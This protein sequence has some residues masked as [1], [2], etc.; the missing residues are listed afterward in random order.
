MRGSV[1]VRIENRH[2]GPKDRRNKIISAIRDFSD[3]ELLQRAQRRSRS[4]P[5]RDLQPVAI[6]LPSDI[7]ERLEPLRPPAYSVSA[8]IDSILAD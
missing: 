7:L 2:G 3:E 5:A 4:N 1:I 8:L 6:M